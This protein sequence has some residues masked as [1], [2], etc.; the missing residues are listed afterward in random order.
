MIF[1]IGRLETENFEFTAYAETPALARELIRKR[2]AKHVKQ[3]SASL[4][5]EDI[6]IW[7]NVYPMEMNT[8]TRQ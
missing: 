5:W 1:Y 2:W 6:K 3:T 7:V 8:A 4:T